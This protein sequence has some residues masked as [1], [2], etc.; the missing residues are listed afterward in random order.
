MSKAGVTLD[1]NNEF[2]FPVVPSLQNCLLLLRF[3]IEVMISTSF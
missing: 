2:I 1:A 3:H